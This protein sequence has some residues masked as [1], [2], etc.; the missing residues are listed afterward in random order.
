MSK[1]VVLNFGR[2]S[3][4]TGFPSVTAELWETNGVRSQQLIGSLPSAPEIITCYREWKH[5]Y[6]ALAQRLRLSLSIEI[7]SASL[8]NV[9][10]DDLH[11]LC[12]RLQV[13]IN[14]WL[15]AESFRKID[16][17]LRTWLS[18]T[19]EVR[20]VIETSDDFLWRL[21]ASLR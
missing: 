21:P 17:K 12:Q 19:E 20:V 6:N 15:N 13:E 9:S 10:Q 2:G 4:E 18:H 16:Q 5:L 3:F 8:T 1:R 7:E 11:G 14:Y